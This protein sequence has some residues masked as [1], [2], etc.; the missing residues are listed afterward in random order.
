VEG[1]GHL[2]VI[3]G[4]L[5]IRA[6][7][8][9]PRSARTVLSSTPTIFAICRLLTGG[10][11]SCVRRAERAVRT[12]FFYGIGRT[13]GLSTRAGNEFLVRNSQFAGANV[14]PPPRSGYRNGDRDRGTLTAMT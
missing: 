7:F 13:T 11:P 12:I 4:W 1:R 10:L 5:F 14:T 8:P 6:G 2:V 3:A 9:A